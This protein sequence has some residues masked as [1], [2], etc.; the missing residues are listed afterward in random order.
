MSELKD[1]VSIASVNNVS[2]CVSFC[3]EN[4]GSFFMEK[5]SLKDVILMALLA[6]LFGGVFMGAGFLYVALEVALTPG[7]YQP[8]AN[9]ILFGLW[10]MAAPMI[11][12]LLKK[13]GSSTLG[14]MLAALAEMLMGSHFG[15][16]VLVSGF[17]QG[18]GTEAGFFA[19]GYKRYDTFSLTLGAIGTVVFS[20]IYEYFKLGYGA[21]SLGF[22][23]ALIVVRFISVFVFGV[24]FVKI[25]M[26]LLEKVKA[27]RGN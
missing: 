14:E 12:V 18:L 17:V 6:F 10:T 13:K 5:W 25:V 27:T 8:F 3:F 16:G 2:E 26:N 21:Y 23:V 9:E 4:E 15:V 19:T 1:L 11:G 22:L 7:G 24:V 20:F